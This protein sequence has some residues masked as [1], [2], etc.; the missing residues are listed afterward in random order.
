MIFF[1]KQCINSQIHKCLTKNIHST[2]SLEPNWQMFNTLLKMH[3]P[4][5][6]QHAQHKLE[7]LILLLEYWQNQQSSLLCSAVSDL[8]QTLGIDT[9]ALSTGQENYLA[10][11][12]KIHYYKNP[13]ELKNIWEQIQDQQIQRAWDNTVPK[14]LPWQQRIFLIQSIFTQKS[15][16]FWRVFETFQFIQEHD[17]ALEQFNN[18]AVS[19]EQLLFEIQTHLFTTMKEYVKTLNISLCPYISEYIPHCFTHFDRSTS[20]FFL[21]IGS[22]KLLKANILNPFF[23]RTLWQGIY[24]AVKDCVGTPV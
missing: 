16:D 7:T 21:W 4:T 23:M 20:R 14:E 24:F 22:F 6:D 3:N 11:Q 1:L 19:S 8:C 2:Q 12:K 18:E 10:I 5:Q 17:D 13:E 9:T 15:L